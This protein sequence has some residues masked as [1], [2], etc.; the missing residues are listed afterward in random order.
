MESSIIVELNAEELAQRTAASIRYWQLLLARGQRELT[1][2]ER[3]ELLAAIRFLSFEPDKVQRDENSVRNFLADSKKVAETPDPK[4]IIEEV[5]KQME[6]L[7]AEKNAFF[8]NWQERYLPLAKK[9]QDAENSQGPLAWA[10]A[11]A[12]NFRSNLP[13]GVLQD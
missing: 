2:D 6:P 12:A 9:K 4:V 1:A 7:L 8:A 3:G 5:N 10:V 11:G 13:P